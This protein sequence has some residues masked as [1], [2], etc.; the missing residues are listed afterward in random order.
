MDF[1]FD[2][3]LPFE[4]LLVG[5]WLSICPI[6]YRTA[7]KTQCNLKEKKWQPHGSFTE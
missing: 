1:K 7:Y 3:L 6:I 2:N 4:G 5:F